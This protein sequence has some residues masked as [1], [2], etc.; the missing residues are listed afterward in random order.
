MYRPTPS[1]ATMLVAIYIATCLSRFNVRIYYKCLD[2][3]WLP[4]NG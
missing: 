4:N 2:K 3:T 1:Y